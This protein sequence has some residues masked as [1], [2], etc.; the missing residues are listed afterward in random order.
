MKNVV[1]SGAV[2]FDGAD[3]NAADSVATG[4]LGVPLPPAPPVRCLPSFV[5]GVF[6]G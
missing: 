1:I 5:G 2:T 6:V 3:P 4:A